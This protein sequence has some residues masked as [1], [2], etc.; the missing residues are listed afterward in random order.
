MGIDCKWVLAEAD[1]KEMNDEVKELKIYKMPERPL[2]HYT[3][4]EVFWKI[5]EGESLLARHILFSNDQEEYKIGRKK[6][7]K[8]AGGLGQSDALPFMVCFCEKPDLLSQWRGYAKEGIAIEFDFSKGLYDSQEGFSSYY[9]YTVMNKDSV[10]E[11]KYLSQSRTDDSKLFLGAIASPYAVFYTNGED[12]SDDTIKEKID[13]I[14]NDAPEESK[15][16]HIAGMIPYVK[17]SRFD[18]EREYRLIFD[19]RQLTAGEQYILSDKYIYLDAD[20]IKKPNIRVKFGN[21]Y[22]AEHEDVIHIYYS[23]NALMDIMTEL[24]AELPDKVYIE[25]LPKRK[26]RKYRIGSGEIFLSEGKSQEMVC[27]SLRK[28]LYGKGIK[29]WCDGHLPIRRI[30]VGPSKD[31]EFMKYSIDEYKKTKYWMED[32][33]VD[34]SKIPLRT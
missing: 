28:K 22:K 19:M 20:G 32:V 1:Q 13:N 21:Q 16:Q 31:A 26:V 24:A 2:Y 27:L 29:I 33:A 12:E 10:T 30:M 3:S 11:D 8:A 5:I 7:E 6:V 9:C 17:N 34:I 4:R 14:L 23:D 15:R 25:P 18:E